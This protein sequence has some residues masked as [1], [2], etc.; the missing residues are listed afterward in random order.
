M[1]ATMADRRRIGL[2]V[3]SAMAS[4]LVDQAGRVG[5]GG[6]DSDIV[7]RDLSAEANQLRQFAL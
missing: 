6:V 4:S 1:T 5:G 2:L 3:R 7:I